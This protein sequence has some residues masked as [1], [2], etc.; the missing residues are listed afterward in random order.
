M[1]KKGKV[2]L[3]SIASLIY[4]EICSG[5][6][7]EEHHFQ[8]QVQPLIGN[9]YFDTQSQ[10]S[11]LPQT[12]DPFAEEQS[13]NNG[14]EM[15]LALRKRKRRPQPEE[16]TASSSSIESGNENDTFFS[17]PKPQSTLP[18][19]RRRTTLSAYKIRE[20]LAALAEE[21]QKR[22]HTSIMRMRKPST[23][24][25]LG[26]TMQPIDLKNILKHSGGLSLVEILQQKNISLDDLLKGKKNALLALQPTTGTTK[27]STTTTTTATDTTTSTTKY[28]K[29]A[30]K[31]PSSFLTSQHPLLSTGENLSSFSSDEPPK[32][33]PPSDDDKAV[34][35]MATIATLRDNPPL[36]K[37]ILFPNLIKRRPLTTIKAKN[38]TT[39]KAAIASTTTT[40]TTAKSTTRMYPAKNRF[41]NRPKLKL[42]SI[43]EQSTPKPTTSST[44]T[45]TTETIEQNEIDEEQ[46]L[47]D[48]EDFIEDDSY[49]KPDSVESEEVPSITSR[50]DKQSFDDSSFNRYYDYDRDELIELLEDQESGNRFLKV[51]NE[52]N[53]SLE[54]FLEQRKRG[55][56]DLHLAMLAENKTTEN[57]P[58]GIFNDK[59][60]IVTAFENFPHFNLVDLKSIRP[61]DIKT[62]SQGSSYFTSIIDIEPTDSDKRLTG[63]PTMQAQQ[64]NHNNHFGAFFPSWKTLALA[65]LTSQENLDKA[66][67]FLSRPT[68]K[69]LRQGHDLIDL[70]L[71]GHGFR[72]TTPT[73]TKKSIFSA[74]VRSALVASSI[75]VAISIGIFIVIF[76]GFRWRQKRRKRLDYTETYNAMKSKLPPLTISQPTSSLNM[77]RMDE[78]SSP[79][80]SPHI[81]PSSSTLRDKHHHH[82][83][84]LSIHHEQP[85]PSPLSHSLT[86]SCRA[87]NISTLDANS[88]EL[89]EYL[90]DSLRKSY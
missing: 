42:P 73:N 32:S 46:L 29:P 20:P 39:I 1:I 41:T 56:S 57:L 75:V 26:T 40:T 55:S 8:F 63:N 65:S 16:N 38:S 60:D 90:F 31:I 11:Q 89:Q 36:R 70:E 62:D 80:S 35:Q 43:V 24:T 17:T 59:L 6:N 84:R 66:H 82:T 64:Q 12:T 25:T 7:D 13:N 88:Q 86:R 48:S 47:D 4:L 51:L 68:E 61:D 22:N 54:E 19:Q 72:K 81:F 27:P 85:P 69:N 34:I 9:Q 18:T 10:P 3:L 77:R 49:L 67:G 83:L 78:L 28:V 2:V 79:H 71:S 33:P 58:V 76:V 5:Q 30:R 87:S 23:T 15:R 74:G 53:M 21:E 50:I 37:N 52:R 44:T 45:T 14:R